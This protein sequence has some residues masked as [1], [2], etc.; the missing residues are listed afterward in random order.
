MSAHDDT[1]SCG[2]SLDV[3]SRWHDGDVVDPALERHIRS[4]AACRAS[5]HDLGSTAT[6]VAGMSGVPHAAARV[7]E[8]TARQGRRDMADFVHELAL[9]CLALHGDALSALHPAEEP[10]PYAAVAADIRSLDRRLRELGVTLELAGLPAAAPRP[11]QALSA[12]RAALGVLDALEGGSERQRR[13]L[14]ASEARRAGRQ[15]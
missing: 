6:A 8:T 10:R 14:A 7:T 11:E 15:N 2:T 1:P 5:L 13:A 12:A 9:A 4:C 3:L